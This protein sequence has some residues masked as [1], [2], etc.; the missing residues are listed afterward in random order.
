MRDTRWETKLFCCNLHNRK[1]IMQIHK[2][3]NQVISTESTEIMDTPHT[4]LFLTTDWLGD[5]W[6]ISTSTM[7][8]PWWGGRE[9]GCQC[10][11]SGAIW[12]QVDALF[13]QHSSFANHLCQ[14]KMHQAKID[15][16]I[17]W[18]H[19]LYFVYFTQAMQLKKQLQNITNQ[20]YYCSIFT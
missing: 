9:Q 20:N 13:Y 4:D 6:V 11:L 15:N 7:L 5:W 14:L 3:W 16:N 1:A 8:R 18:P 19:Y 2:H 12:Y 17:N 10:F